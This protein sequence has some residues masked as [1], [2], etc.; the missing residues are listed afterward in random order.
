MVLGVQVKG[1]EIEANPSALLME[2]DGIDTENIYRSNFYVAGQIDGRE[3]NDEEAFSSD[4][5]ASWFADFPVVLSHDP[6]AFTPTAEAPF[7]GMGT[8]SPAAPSDRNGIARHEAPAL[9]P[10]ELP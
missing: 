3:V 4:F 5:S 2:I 1:G 7:V 10:V 6:N 9:G 8:L